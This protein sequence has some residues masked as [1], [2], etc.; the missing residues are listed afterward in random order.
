MIETVFDV[1][2]TTLLANCPVDTRNMVTHITK[3][4]FGDYFE[5]TISGP[6]KYGDYAE[7][8]NKQQ[9]VVKSGPNKGKLNYQWIEKTCQQVADLFGDVSYEIS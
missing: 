5:I 9:T 6:S 8:V 2:F 7:Y 4:D 1:L 3:E